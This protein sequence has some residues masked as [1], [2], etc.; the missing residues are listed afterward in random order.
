MDAGDLADLALAALGD[1]DDVGRLGQRRQAGDARGQR[2]RHTFG[3]E[4]GDARQPCLRRGL[5]QQG[6]KLAGQLLHALG[7]AR[8]GL[9]DR[10]G[11]GDAA[12]QEPAHA[13]GDELL[14][15]AI[16]AELGLAGDLGVER[17]DLAVEGDEIEGIACDRVS[18]GDGRRVGAG[19]RRQ[20]RDESRPAAVDDRVGE[21]RRDDL[22]PQLVA[23]DRVR[24]C[25]AQR[26]REIADEFAGEIGIVRH[27]GFEQ[28]VVQREL[29]IGQEHGEFRPGQAFAA[30]LALGE[31]GVARQ[32]L[33][34]A[35]EFSVLLQRLHQEAQA[36]RRGRALRFG[37]R[38]RQR[39]QVVV[40]QDEIA[41]LVGH[42]RQQFVALVFL[43]AAVLHR[44]GERD[45]DVDLDVG[46][47][48]AGRVVDR[49]GV[50][51]DAPARGL[52][53]A[54]LGDAEIGTLADDPRPEIVAGDA[55]RVIGAVA[56]LRVGLVGG[57][58]IG[59]DAAEPE[60]I[61]A[62]FE[63]RRHQLGR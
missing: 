44:A 17:V 2:L 18:R 58:D 25:L 29:G 31:L 20:N 13:V 40:A 27:R 3:G 5:G 23:G 61:D 43:Q 28:R 9:L 39:L 57:A 37:Q 41:D 53:A 7:I 56:D 63:D 52:D 42:R 15:G 33:D 21:L 6:A 14:R 10:A 62:A 47:V 60:Q 30:L 49:V 48:D 46:G 38:E 16:E 50:E 8:D 26:L 22:A 54:A 35:V 32:V 34:R 19:Q 59:A 4:H 36:R 12:P 11:L 55:D 1:V 45:L 51:L 24:I